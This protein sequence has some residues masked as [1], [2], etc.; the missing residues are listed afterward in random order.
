MATN[1]DEYDGYFI[2]KG[3]IV[4]GNGWWVTKTIIPAFS[5]DFS[6]FRSIMHDPK[7]WKNRMEFQPE[8][9]LKDGKINPDVLD[10]ASVAFGYGRRSVLIKLIQ[11]ISRT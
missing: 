4:F 11:H 10:P 9:F 3:T 1:D 2:P 8:R 7:I 5:P 6:W